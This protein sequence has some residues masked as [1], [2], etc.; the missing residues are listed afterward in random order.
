MLQLAHQTQVS[1]EDDFQPGVHDHA[2]GSCLQ[3]LRNAQLESANEYSAA[4]R[5]SDY[6]YRNN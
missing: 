5:I 2:F 3:R 1:P 4:S 6:C